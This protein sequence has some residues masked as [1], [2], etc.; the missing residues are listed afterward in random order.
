V[1]CFNHYFADL[2]RDVDF[3]NVWLPAV[4]E[5]TDLMLAD[6]ECQPL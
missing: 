3:Y 4:K 1:T 6:A 5:R 2:N